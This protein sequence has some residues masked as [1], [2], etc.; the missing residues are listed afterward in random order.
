MRKHY[1]KW[2]AAGRHEFMICWH[3]CGTKNRL[4]KLLWIQKLGLVDLVRFELTTSSMPFK[5][6]QR[7]ADI[8]NGNKDLAARGLTP[9]DSTGGLLG[10]WTPDGLQ[11]STP[12]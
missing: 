5:K 10:V 2:S 6:Y 12:G 9:V 4:K 8:P 1:A 7:V 3:V 11:D